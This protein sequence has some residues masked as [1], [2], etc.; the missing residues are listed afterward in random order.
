M[1]EHVA[2]ICRIILNHPST[3]A[4]RLMANYLDHLLSFDTPSYT[5]AQI[6]KHF[7][8]ITVLRAFHT[9]QPLSFAP[10]FLSFF[11][12]LFFMAA[13]WNSAGYYI[14][15]LWFHLSIFFLS[16]FS[17]PNLSRRR[18]DVCHTSTHSVALVRI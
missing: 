2:V 1:Q 18:L 4:M 14:F 9:I 5:V 8:P 11:F 12:F 17:S 7:E 3:A 6:A 13:L 10:L 16:S 15:A